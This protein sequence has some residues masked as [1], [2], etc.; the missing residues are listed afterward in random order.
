MQKYTPPVI[1]A[2]PLFVGMDVHKK[3]IAVCVYDNST[4]AIVDERQLPNDWPK[5]RKY[6]EQVQKR[7]GA[8]QWCYEASSCGYP[9]FLTRAV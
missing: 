1:S 3:T 2:S 4:G 6:I 8:M 9:G 5:V 7:H